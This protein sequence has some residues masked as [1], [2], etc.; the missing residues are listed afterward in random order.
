MA[1]N[2]ENHF[3]INHLGSLSGKFKPTKAGLTL[4][5]SKTRLKIT[6]VLNRACVKNLQ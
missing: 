1:F 5:L 3:E 4:K 6:S 2:K